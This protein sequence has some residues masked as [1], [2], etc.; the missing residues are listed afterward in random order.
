MTQEQQVER[1]RRRVELVR[2]SLETSLMILEALAADVAHLVPG[3]YTPC[4]CGVAKEP[5]PFGLPGVCA[6]GREARER[7]G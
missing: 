2:V 1:L 6:A 4:F 3:L 7:L 5:H